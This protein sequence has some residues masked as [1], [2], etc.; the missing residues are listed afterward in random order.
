[1]TALE[2]NYR[3][4]RKSAH[5]FEHHLQ[6][7]RDL[8]DR[9]ETDAARDY[10]DLRFSPTQPAQLHPLECPAVLLHFR[11]MHTTFPTATIPAHQSNVPSS[12]N[13]NLRTPLA[14][15]TTSFVLFPNRCSTVFL[16]WTTS[17]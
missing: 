1:M 17:Y 10:A 6:V 11:H 4:Q 14:L 5:E 8:L 3:M 13:V 9:E 15:S 12:R 7:L 2:Q 16:L